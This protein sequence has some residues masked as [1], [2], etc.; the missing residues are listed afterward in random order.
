MR[1]DDYRTQQA[2]TE[3]MMNTGMDLEWTVCS[4]GSTRPGIWK[5]HMVQQVHPSPGHA[6][7]PE[8]PV[9]HY[10]LRGKLKGWDFLSIWA[11]ARAIHGTVRCVLEQLHSYPLQSS[12][13]SLFGP[14]APK[15]VVDF[16][17]RLWWLLT[18]GSQ[19]W[20]QSQKLGDFRA[21]PFRE[22]SSE[23]SWARMDKESLSSLK[24][25]VLGVS[26]VSVAP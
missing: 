6:W 17:S 4:S 2:Q 18:I 1:L 11:T 22:E 7:T 5:I 13:W 14:R 19:T 15:S 23:I 26:G 10:L 25:C 9:A 20:V 21:P 3:P 12:T 16:P 8:S 24:D